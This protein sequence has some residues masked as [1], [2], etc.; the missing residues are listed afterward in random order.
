MLNRDISVCG[1]GN[2]QAGV[3]VVNLSISITS[4]T[5]LPPFFQVNRVITQFQVEYVISTPKKTK[6]KQKQNKTTQCDK[7]IQCDHKTECQVEH[8]ITRHNVR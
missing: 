3:D 7:T 2:W 8:V 5:E 6:Q 1:C 4:S